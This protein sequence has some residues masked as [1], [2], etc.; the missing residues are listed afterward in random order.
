[1]SL[2]N[3]TIR[4]RIGSQPRERAGPQAA[5]PAFPELPEGY[6][7]P[8]DIH[9]GPDGLTLEGDLPGADQPELADPGRGQ[10]PSVTCE[11]RFAGTR[12]CAA[13]P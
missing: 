8:V 9:E 10:C 4:V 7:P 2:E 12:G 6:I 11:G 5:Q 13:G 3:P 1:M